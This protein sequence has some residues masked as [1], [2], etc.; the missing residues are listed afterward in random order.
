MDRITYFVQFLRL[1]KKTFFFKLVDKKIITFQNSGC[2]SNKKF[3]YTYKGETYLE[4]LWDIL[5]DM[6]HQY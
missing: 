1:E 2:H 3:P 6:L 4:K 5:N